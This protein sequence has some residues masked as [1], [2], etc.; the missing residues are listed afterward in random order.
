MSEQPVQRPQLVGPRGDRYPIAPGR[1]RI[2]RHPDNAIRIDHETVGRHH[3]EIIATGAH[4]VLTDLRSTNGTWVNDERLDERSAVDLRHGDVVRLGNLALRFVA[5]TT[6]A[7]GLPP[8]TAGRAAGGTSYGVGDV[9]GG[10]Q[11]GSGT[12][13]NVGRDQYHARGD[14]H[15]IHGGQHVVHGG[16]Y[17]DSRVNL[18][19]D[20]DP[21]DE[22][23][24]GKG[25][26]RVLMVLGTL[27]ALGGFG[28]FVYTIFLG[29]TDEDPFEG[30]DPFQRE[31]A[32]VPMFAVG[33]GL[34]FIGGVLAGVGG[35]MAKAKRK[36]QERAEWNRPVAGW[37][38]RRR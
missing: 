15:V 30:P 4:V 20:Y 16:Q 38:G 21:S 13:H 17:N 11:I 29:F 28:L 3:A 25:I 12:Q 23:F 22:F 32:G 1:S 27:I 37:D 9:G 26:G 19:A 5:V 31:I 10:V 14:Q 6:T 7:P 33:F 35:T 36:K 2:G 8:P 24:L 18:T 34:F